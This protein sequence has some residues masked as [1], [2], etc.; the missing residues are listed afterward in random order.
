MLSL[1]QSFHLIWLERVVLHGESAQDLKIPAAGW[2]TGG[3]LN[4]PALSSY[5]QAVARTLRKLDIVFYQS[6]ELLEKAAAPPRASHE[7]DVS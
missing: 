7:R 5:G 4:F 1:M 6:H 3:D 2:A